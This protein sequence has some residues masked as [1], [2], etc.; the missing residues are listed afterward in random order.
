MNCYIWLSKEKKKSK[1][2]KIDKRYG[3]TLK[4][5]LMQRPRDGGTPRYRREREMEKRWR[6]ERGSWT[7]NKHMRRGKWKPDIDQMTQRP[8]WRVKN[9]E[10]EKEIEKQRHR[11]REIDS[12]WESERERE[13]FLTSSMFSHDQKPDLSKRSSQWMF[14]HLS[15]VGLYL[16]K[17]T[18]RAREDA[19]GRCLIPREYFL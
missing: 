18:P 15:H 4:K 3:Q 2:Q 17:P 13:I 9:S 10:R 7:E 19:D 5:R 6:R 11:E 14:P 16:H 1:R 12:A 8:G